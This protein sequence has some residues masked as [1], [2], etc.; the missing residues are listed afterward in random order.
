MYVNGTSIGTQTTAQGYTSTTSTGL[1][2]GGN[3]PSISNYNGYIDDL[4]FTKGYARYTAN[5]TPPTSTF[6]VR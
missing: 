1:K 3:V 5:F 2:I 4:R 6:L